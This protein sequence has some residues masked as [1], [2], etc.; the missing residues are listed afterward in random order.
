LE[1]KLEEILERIGAP[2]E[3]HYDIVGKPDFAFPELKVALFAD[4]R[5][6]HGYNWNKAKKEIKTNKD[7]W[8]KKIER[9]IQRDREVNNTL[10]TLGWTVIRFWEHDIINDPEVCLNKIAATLK[11]RE[12][13]GI[14]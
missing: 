9:N 5:F 3:K 10:R 4:S 14:C 12:K 1:R 7:F 11:D 8:I 6:W 13:R 2:Y